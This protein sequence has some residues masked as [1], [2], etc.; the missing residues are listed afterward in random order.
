MS[1][2]GT[3]TFVYQRATAILLAPLVLWFLFSVV[4]HAGDSYLEARAWAAKPLNMLLLGVMV[5]VGA[6]HMR[7]GMM[8]IIE[9]YIHGEINGL[10]NTLNWAVAI[11]VTIATWWSLFANAAA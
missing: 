5:T 7:I 1:N 3:S 10:L 4:A 8:E 9:D 11:S 6:F 2:K